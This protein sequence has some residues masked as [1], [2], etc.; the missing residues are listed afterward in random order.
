MPSSDYT[1]VAGGALKLKG[2]GVDKKKKKKK[3]KPAAD[4]TK[5]SEEAPTDVAKR[6]TS[7]EDASKSHSGTPGRSLSPESAERSI[8]E[9]GGR[10][11]TEAEKRYD[12][13][14]RKRLEER[15]RKEGVKTHKEKV[16]ELNK[17]L[18][19]LSEHHDMPKIGPG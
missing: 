12:E 13:M 7:D 19:A 11:K 6:P 10:H 17:Y 5:V 16:E 8:R 3:A 18:S 15:M 1:A 9:G 4:T 2:V 14:R